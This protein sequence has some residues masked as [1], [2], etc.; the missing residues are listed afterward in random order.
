MDDLG[1]LEPRRCSRLLKI[2]ADPDR[3]RII[4]ALRAGPLCVT[5]VA[6]R[7]GL[8]LAMAS[9]HLRILR[10]SGFVAD[11]KQGRHVAYSLAP[12][13]F[14]PGSAAEPT[15]QLGCCQLQLPA[16]PKRARKLR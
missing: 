4:Q 5:D 7:L 16:A 15:I 10:T 2:L 13:F 1:P 8:T 9:H 11:D 14:P 6:E 3:L 12:E